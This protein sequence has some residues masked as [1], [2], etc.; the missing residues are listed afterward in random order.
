[1]PSHISA[2]A[3]SA[4]SRR[5]AVAAPTPRISPP[6]NRTGRLVL[7]ADGV[8][9]VESN[10][11]PVPGQRVLAGFQV[12]ARDQL[13]LRLDAE[14]VVDVIELVFLDEQRVPAAGACG[15]R[16]SGGELLECGDGFR[17]APTIVS[18]YRLEKEAP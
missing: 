16:P 11:A 15:G 13:L 8:A 14:E 2:L 6:W 10:A 3:P 17:G 7:A 18:R 9:A 4:P 1:M 5:R 12:N